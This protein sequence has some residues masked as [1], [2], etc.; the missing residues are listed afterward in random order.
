VVAE[1]EPSRFAEKTAY[2]AYDCH[3]LDDEK[4]YLL[5]TT[6]AGKTWTSINGDLPEHGST[7]VVRED[8]THP[9]VLYVGTEFG[10]FVTID[11]GSHWERLEGNLPRVGT[12]SLAIQER[13]K[14]LVAATY[15]RSIW[16]TDIAPF[17]EM[18]EGA[19]DKPLHLFRSNPAML[20]KTR[21]TY[22]NTIEELNGDM[23]F[24]AENPPDGAVITYFLGEALGSDIAVE[25]EDTAGNVI[26]HLS[27]AGDAGI[28]RIVWDLKTDETAEKIRPRRALVTMSEWEFAQKVSSGRY[29]VTLRA[30]NLV[31]RGFVTVRDAPPKTSVR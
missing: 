17:A 16:V 7:W 14:D 5:K 27:G 19:L 11:G 25:I 26:R 4:P 8:P 1:I 18:A 22:G 6:D 9:A 13:E 15:G 21:V 20:F 30:G 2:V 12:R 28:H 23:F 24:R 3:K 10:I 31:E 29:G